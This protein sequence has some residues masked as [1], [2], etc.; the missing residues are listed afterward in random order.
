[1]R[2]QLM[3]RCPRVAECLCGPNLFFHREVRI[4]TAML[5][6]PLVQDVPQEGYE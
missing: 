4:I 5:L 3:K 6:L 1:M 2:P